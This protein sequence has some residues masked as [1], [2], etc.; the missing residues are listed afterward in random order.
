[1]TVEQLTKVKLVDICTAAP[2]HHD[3]SCEGPVHSHSCHHHHDDDDDDDD[4]HDHDHDDHD[5]DDDH[6]VAGVIGG[7]AARA[8][9]NR[10]M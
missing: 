8:I 2:H 9:R 6:K 3:H 1:M 5:H 7:M 10:L 4:H